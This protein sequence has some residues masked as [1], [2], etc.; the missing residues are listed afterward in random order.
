MASALVQG[1]CLRCNCELLKNWESGS[2]ELSFLCVNEPSVILPIFLHMGFMT[3]RA[4]I[5]RYFGCLAGS[6][7]F[8]LR[9]GSVFYPQAQSRFLKTVVSTEAYSTTWTTV[10]TFVITNR[11]PL[12]SNRGRSRLLILLPPS[13]RFLFFRNSPS[14]TSRGFSTSTALNVEVSTGP[15]SVVVTTSLFW[16]RSIPRQLL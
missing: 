7:Y 8:Q 12:F 2:E 4:S 10:I 15:S 5:L 9:L 1:I 16:K 13:K 11:S 3:R 6:N 14:T